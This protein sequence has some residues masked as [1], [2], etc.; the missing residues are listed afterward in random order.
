[1]ISDLLKPIFGHEDLGSEELLNKC[2]HGL[3]QNVNE[4]MHNV[5]W[6]K[7]SKRVYVGMHTIQ[8]GV[9][10]AV[11]SYDGGLGLLPVFDKLKMKRGQCRMNYLV[12]KDSER[13]KNMETKMCKK[14]LKRRK[15]LRAKRKGFSDICVEKEG[16]TY[17]SGA[18]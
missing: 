12:K 18:F 4:A 9:A 11:I 3:T 6:Q 5:I 17:S 8:L 15:Q 16:E 10:S 13:I 14:G 7:C 2:L 1:M